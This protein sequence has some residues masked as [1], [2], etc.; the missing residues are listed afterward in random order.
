M[1]LAVASTFDSEVFGY[2]VGILRP[3]L[4][5]PVHAVRKAS[6]EF[7]DVVIVKLKDWVDPDALVTAIDYSYD[8][9]FTVPGMAPRQD[10]CLM[11]ARPRHVEIARTSFSDSRFL[12]DRKLAA[13]TPDF[14]ARWVRRGPIHALKGGEDSGF[15]LE[16]QDDD[17]AR[18]IALLAIDASCRGSGIGD[19]LVW[20]VLRQ[21]KAQLWRVRVSSRNHRAIRFYESVGFRVRSVW[22]TYHVWVEGW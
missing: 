18:R 3:D 21:D 19:A 14:Y 15:L 1:T 12:R 2:R 7:F 4:P 13:R 6:R 17:G 9:E 5:V 10:T 22:T 11:P 16:S 20:G 8:M